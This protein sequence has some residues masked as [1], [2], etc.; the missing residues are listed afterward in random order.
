MLREQFAQVFGAPANEGLQIPRLLHHI[1]YQALTNV[2]FTFENVKAKLLTMRANSSPGSDNIHPQ[3]L[4]SVANQIA[5]PLA[6]LFQQMFDGTLLPQSWKQGIISPI[7]K[8]GCRSDPANYRPVTLLPVLSKVMESIVADFV[9]DH[10]ERHNILSPAQHRFRKSR[11]CATNLLLARDEWTTTVDD[12]DAVDV[13]YLDFSKAFDRVNHQILLRKLYN[14]GIQG[15]LLDWIELFLR[16]RTV[17]VRVSDSV[18]S[19]IEVIRGVP[20]GSVLGPRLFLAFINDLPDILGPKTLLFADD[21]KIWQTVTEPKG[22]IAL[23]NTL[24]A[25]QKWSINNDIEFNVPKCKVL[26][27]RHNFRFQYFL[28]N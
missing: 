25:A 21:A 18:S 20:Q 13:I 14:Y 28:G 3:P 12:G 16:Q 19:P 17:S 5:E 22:Q 6:T 4:Q 24:D 27:L 15:L 7:Y 23:Q 11:S 1:P 8:G 10:M 2:T 9:M 26:S